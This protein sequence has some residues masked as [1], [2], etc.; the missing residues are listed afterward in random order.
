MNGK[1]LTDN[2]LP[3]DYGPKH[4]LW[5]SPSCRNRYYRILSEESAGLDVSLDTQTFKYAAGSRFG[6]PPNLRACS[7]IGIDVIRR[8][9]FACKTCFYRWGPEFNTSDEILDDV[10]AL[11]RAGR[12]RGCDHVVLIG[13]GEPGL[14]KPIFE[15]ISE[16]KNIG[17]TSSII[18]NGSMPVTHYAKMREAGLN[19]LHVSVHGLGDTLDKI[20]CH[21]GAG[22]KQAELMAMAYEH[23]LSASEL[24][25]NARHSDPV[26]RKWMQAYHISRLSSAL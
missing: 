20:V 2:N 17:M 22:A 18:T 7:R 26:H 15:F 6:I 23:D 14:W 1:K 21:Y 24:Q 16:V 4:P 11:T 5:K 8:C 12:D 9:N 19:H 13:K 3:A 25:R 10:L